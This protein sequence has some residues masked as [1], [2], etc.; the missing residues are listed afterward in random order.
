MRVEQ[1]NRAFPTIDRAVLVPDTATYLDELSKWSP[2][3]RWPVLLADDHFAPMFLRAF[4]PGQIVRRESVLA[5]DGRP[6]TPTTQQLE[7]IVIRAWGGNPELHSLRDTFAGNNYTPPGVVISSVDDP[8]WTAAVALAA[9]RG[10]PLLWF[11]DSAG[12]PNQ[13]LDRAALDRLLASVD[14]LVAST[15]YAH[16]DLGDA[17]DAITMCRTIAGRVNMFPGGDQ[18]GV[19]AVTDVLGRK[20]SGARYA[21][22]GWIFGDEV[23][24][25]YM[26]MCSLFLDRSRVWLYNTYPDEEGWMAYG[27]GAATEKLTQSGYTT[28]RSEGA[29]AGQ[30]PWLRMLAGGIDTD[31]LAINSKGHVDYMELSSGTASAVDV[32]ML[33]TPIALH[34]IHSWSMR[35]PQTEGTLGAQWLAHGAYAYVGS[36]HEPLLQAFVPPTALAERWTKL[37]P[38]LV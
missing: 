3:G 35:S 29:A 22:A 27:L 25:A 8:A 33:T 4:K 26:A 18:D 34:L 24:S 37:A 6:T 31:V 16:A 2:K 5:P 12:R 20:P 23:H 9:G 17:I 30:S 11:T 13:L 32:P 21:F 19:R 36:V 1:V 7:A 15:G 10:Q 38:F 14:E 28:K